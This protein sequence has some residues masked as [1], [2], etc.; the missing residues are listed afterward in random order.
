[1]AAAIFQA[2]K[3]VDVLPSAIWIGELGLSGDV[4][5]VRGIIGQLL[6]AKTMGFT[7]CFIPAANLEQAK[8]IPE[9]TLLPVPNLLTLFNH[10][11]G[12]EL[13]KPT[14]STGYTTRPSKVRTSNYEVRFEDIGSHAQAKRLLEIAAAG[15]HNVLFSGP[16]GTGK[17]MLA[18]ALASILPELHHDEL[19]EVTH[20]NSLASSRFEQ[21]ICERPFRAP[22]H[23]ASQASIIGDGP[24]AKPGEISLAHRGVLFLDELP[25]Y[26]RNTIEALRQPLEDKQITI[27]RANRSATYPSDF[28]LVATCNPCPCGFYGML[29]A[30]QRPCVC[31]PY[32]IMQYQR[33]LSGPLLDRI[34][35]YSDIEAVAHDKLLSESWHETSQVVRK[36]VEQARA[37][38]AKRL[39]K[40]GMTNAQMSNRELKDF[41]KLNPKAQTLL[42]Q[43]ASQLHLSARAYMRT[44]K[45]ARTIADLAQS[46]DIQTE[47]IAE[48]LQYRRHTQ[49]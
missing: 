35:L 24:Q 10:L 27:V 38:Q 29:S 42:N 30:S 11:T 26:S 12:V 21:I 49:T 31:M 41:A 14:I 20:V 28:M 34:D 6:A 22:H 2:G 45:V 47:H 7:T 33:R 13:I 8:L 17:S 18:K 36:R 5:P 37:A 3:L 46:L 43:A 32:Q 15:G 25:E 1:M 40:A 9:L 4:R 39:K 19:L 48:A 16:P 23:S 44:I